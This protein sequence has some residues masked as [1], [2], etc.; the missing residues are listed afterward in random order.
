L[1]L[2]SFAGMLLTIHRDRLRARTPGALIAA[3]F[4]AF[5]ALSAA[6]TAWGRAN[7]DDSGLSAANASRFTLFGGYLCIGLVLFLA[8]LGTDALMHP[9]FARWIPASRQRFVLRLAFVL[10]VLLAIGSYG[11]SIKVYRSAAALNARLIDAYRARQDDP[12][13]LATIFPHIEMMT[14]YKHEMQRHHVGAFRL[15]DETDSNS[16]VP[17][18]ANDFDQSERGAQGA[19]NCQAITA[20]PSGMHQKANH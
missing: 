6:M 9:T 4:L 3:S 1:L 17:S 8:S 2:L 15:S 19:S 14:L 11:M 5:A 12:V 7:F 13:V 18:L 20:R 10:F 16:A